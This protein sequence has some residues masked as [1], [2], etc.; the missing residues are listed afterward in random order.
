MLGEYLDAGQTFVVMGRTDRLQLEGEVRQYDIERVGDGFPVRLKVAARPNHTFVGTVTEIAPA[1]RSAEPG[2]DVT[3]TIWADLD[4]GESL[5][6][7]GL[8]ARAKVLG[9]R[10]PIGYIIARPLIRWINMTFWR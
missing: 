3:V 1:A 7:P 5:L 4:N 10:R 8:E 9:A 6:R 2:G